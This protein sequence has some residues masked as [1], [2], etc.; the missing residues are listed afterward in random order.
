VGW[1][2]VISR[3]ITR[4]VR[5]LI[6]FTE[7]V[8]KGNLD[9]RVD[10]AG[11]DEISVLARS[12][13]RMAGDLAASR[14]QLIRAEKE[15]AWREMARQ[16]A[17]E[18]KNPLTPMRMCAQLLLRARREGDPRWQELADRL[19]NNVLQQTDALDRIASDF[20]QFAGSPVRQVVELDADEMLGGIEELV[21]SM[22][23]A[24]DVDIAFRP[25]ASG[26]RVAVD[27]QEIRRVFLN[28]IHN[29]MQ[30]CRQQGSVRVRS[31]LGQNGERR[32]VEFRVE[33]DGAGV[34]TA[35]RERLFEPY[36]TTKTAGT[37]LGLA[38]C[39]R[40]VEAHGGDIRLEASGPPRTVFL[41]T[42]PAADTRA[43]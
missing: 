43:G 2:W 22:A 10:A 34:S 11:T 27:V 42:L 13:N 20:R 3:T 36:F 28:L 29:A 40:I 7:E 6:A 14:E 16:I 35:V 41:V 17:H 9:A 19:A 5:G 8:A 37:G 26:V 38:I 25:G 33:D 23:E 31:D 21:G 32:T 12:F 24:T 15:A 18:I 4:P 30:A 39:R 1:T